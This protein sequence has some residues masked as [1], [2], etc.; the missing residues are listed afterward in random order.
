MKN[1]FKR[2]N[3]LRNFWDSIKKGNLLI[4]IQ[5]GERARKKK[6]KKK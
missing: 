6:L 2:D 4:R 1:N 3:I 5:K